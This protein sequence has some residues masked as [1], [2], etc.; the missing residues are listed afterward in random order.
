MSITSRAQAEGAVTLVT[1]DHFRMVL[2]HFP[3]GVVVV[4]GS[5]GGHPVGM[6]V[7]SF[8][9]LSLE[10]PL[11]GFAADHRSHTWPLLQAA[12]TFCVNVLGEDQAG[13]ASW[14]AKRGVDRFGHVTWAPSPGG[15]PIIDGAIAWIDC[16]LHAA[17]SIGDHDLVTATVRALEAGQSGSGPL[18]FYRR[19]YGGFR[20][21]G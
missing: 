21:M 1:P 4:A 17:H 7:G 10:P 16:D 13:L 14:F 12:G 9:S 11:V 3:T 20:P 6:T 15:S 19:A 18:L 8:F 5:A 2:G